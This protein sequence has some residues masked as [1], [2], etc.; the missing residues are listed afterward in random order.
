LVR[1]SQSARDDAM[2]AQYDLFGPD[3]GAANASKDLGTRIVERDLP[4][5]VRNRLRKVF[6]LTIQLRN[7]SQGSQT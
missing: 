5:A 1:G 4:A 3:Y 6:T 7:K 2:N